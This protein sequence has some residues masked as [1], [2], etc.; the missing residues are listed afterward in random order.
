MTSK[1]FFLVLFVSG[2]II[3]NSAYPQKG[4]AKFPLNEET[5]L[6]TYQAVVNEEGTSEQFF[7]RAIA[8]INS[9][10]ANPVDVTKTRD[11]ETGLIKG[12]HRF[13]IMNTDAE[14]NQTDA[15]VVQYEFSLEFKE[16]RYRYT[17]TNFVLKESSKIPVERWFDKQDP[18]YNP[19]WD[20]Y[21]DQV[22]EFSIN[23]IKS[24]KD[25]MKPK[26]KIKNDQ[27]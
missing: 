20:S 8:W 26:G 6:I 11:P 5:G 16:G 13:K 24:L 12:L 1:R 9:Y 19:A 7:N 23:W 3:Q 17:I 21:L 22:F 14:G 10:Y 25:G 27:W 15:G 4:S 18:Q 2:F